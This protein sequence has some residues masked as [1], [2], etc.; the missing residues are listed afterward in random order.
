VRTPIPDDGARRGYRFSVEGARRASAALFVGR[1]AERAAPHRS[2]GRRAA[3]V[4]SSSSGNAG[5]GKTALLDHFL[6]DSRRRRLA[7]RAPG[8]R[9]AGPRPGLH[10]S[11]RLAEPACDEAGG[12]EVVQPARRALGWL[13]QLPGSV[14][15]G[16]ADTLRARVSNSSWEAGLLELGEALESLASEKPLVL[17]L[18]DLH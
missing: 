5:A 10:G 16:T 14:D 17:V 4:K 2:R 13:L 3:S 7:A 11:A 8:A 12:D 15:D 6:D 18:E 9:A 1:D